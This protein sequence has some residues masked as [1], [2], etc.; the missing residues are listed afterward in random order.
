MENCL[1]T[2]FKG[3]SDNNN[4]DIFGKVVVFIPY[5]ENPEQAYTRQIIVTPKQ[6]KTLHIV[7]NSPVS[8]G[9]HEGQTDFTVSTVGPSYLIFTNRV[10][11]MTI[12]IDSVYNIKTLV[13]ATGWIVKG[14][15]YL[16]GYTN[17]I[18]FN[19]QPTGNNFNNLSKNNALVSL[20]LGTNYRFVDDIMENIEDKT[21]LKNIGPSAGKLGNKVAEFIKLQKIQMAVDINYLP[22]TIR[23][24]TQPVNTSG[25]LETFVNNMRNAGRT[26]GV[27][28]FSNIGDSRNKVTYD[29]GLMYQKFNEAGKTISSNNFVKW[30]ANNI[31]LLDATPS[32]FVAAENFVNYTIE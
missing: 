8:E 3:V 16:I 21:H 29:G 11:G 13:C 23:E 5:S 25:S 10:G 7:S 18:D 24:V 1:V 2:K 19:F 6:G 31:E 20:Y 32:D 15:N 12:T 28:K 4:L 17:W 27:I 9:T 22:S 30:T 14:F 26:T